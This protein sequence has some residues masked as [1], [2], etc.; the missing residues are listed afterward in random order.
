MKYSFILFGVL[1]G[2]LLSRAGATTPDFY[3]NLFLFN[4][5]QLMWVIAT[6]VI[7]GIVGV[8]ILKKI[9]ARAIFSGK[10]L[11]FDKRPM[12]RGLVYGALLFGVGWGMTGSCPGTVPAMIGEGRLL[13]LFTL[14][15]IVLGTYL[16]DIRR[17]KIVK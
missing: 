17:P 16:Y 3:A 12:Q 4:N 15:G 2:F 9:S 7:V 1:F 5:L 14:L 13:P 11:S 8:L 6:A 10:L